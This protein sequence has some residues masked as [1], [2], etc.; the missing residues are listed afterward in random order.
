MNNMNHNL[1]K[2][3]SGSKDVGSISS[4]SKMVRLLITRALENNVPVHKDR[5]LVTKLSRLEAMEIAPN[6][7]YAAIAEIMTYIHSQEKLTGMEI[8]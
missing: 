3:Y 6:K 2:T 5:E 4:K 7:Y 1:N 8:K